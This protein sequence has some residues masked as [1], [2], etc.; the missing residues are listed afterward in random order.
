MK[1]FRIIKNWDW[2]GQLTV[3]YAILLVVLLTCFSLLIH[4]VATV[5]LRKAYKKAKK[6]NKELECAYYS[7]NWFQKLFWCGLKGNVNKMYFLINFVEKSLLMCSILIVFL[8]IFLPLKIFS[9]ILRVAGLIIWCIY[10]IEVFT[11]KKAFKFYNEH[12]EIK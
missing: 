5:E 6:K 2:S 12:K 10:I 7:K 9:D 3:G 1:L 4:F 8:Y 11:S